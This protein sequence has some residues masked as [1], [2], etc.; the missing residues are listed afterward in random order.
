MEE[1][2]GEEE[3]AAQ[4]RTRPGR[5]GAGAAALGARGTATAV[6]EGERGA[7]EEGKRRGRGKQAARR[8][9]GR[10]KGRG[11]WAAGWAAREAG[12]VGPCQETGPREEGGLFYLFFPIFHYPFPLIL[13]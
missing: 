13:Y 5:P 1:R 12:E 3:G 8:G 9:W 11:G 6:G 10:K 7:A 4:G 2:G